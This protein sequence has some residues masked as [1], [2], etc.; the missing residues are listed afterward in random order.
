LGAGN[1]FFSA[2]ITALASI[3]VCGVA[4]HTINRQKV[5]REM[6]NLKS[7][8]TRQD[9]SS[10][11]PPI[12][13]PT[14]LCRLDMLGLSL[15]AAARTT[16]LNARPIISIRIPLQSSRARSTPIILS[17][18]KSSV[19]PPRF[20]QSEPPKPSSDTTTSREL[21]PSDQRY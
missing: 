8:F 2:S 21:Y 20:D 14:L 5:G 17:R 9:Q 11:C 7:R 1:S 3:I 13:L 15:R 4:S 10:I 16:S 6:R 19:P 12:H 18:Y